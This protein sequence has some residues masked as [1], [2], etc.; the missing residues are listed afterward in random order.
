MLRSETVIVLTF[1]TLV[2]VAVPID[3]PAAVAAVGAVNCE[4]APAVAARP[5]AGKNGARTVPVATI[6]IV[7]PAAAVVAV[8]ATIDEVR[9]VVTPAVVEVRVLVAEVTAV[10]EAT[11]AP[12]TT[13]P[14]AVATSN[15]PDTVK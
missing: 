13:E 2:T 10:A 4:L 14:R 6:T 8:P 5:V 11:P 9:V 15:A 7:L 3:P 12:I 1:P